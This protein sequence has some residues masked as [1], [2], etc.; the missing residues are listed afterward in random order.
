MGWLGGVALVMMSGC[1]GGKGNQVT[2]TQGQGGA[3]G[4]N[5]IEEARLLRMSDGEGYV[6]AEVVNPWDTTR[7]LGRYLLVERGEEPG[8]GQSAG[9]GAEQGAGRGMEQ[10]AGRSAERGAKRGAEADSLPEGY[11]RIEVPLERALVYSSVHGGVIA[12]MGAEGRIAGVADGEYF[13]KE[14]LAGRIKRGEVRNVGSSMAPSMEAIVALGPDAILLSPFENAGHGVVEH[15]GVPIIE[16]ADYM[17]NTPKGRAEWIKLLGVLFGE[18]ERADSIY[19]AVSAAY[20]SIAASVR[21]KG[22]GPTVLTEQLRDGYWFV[23]GG[24][25]YMARMIGDAGGV[26]PWANDGNTG[27]LQ[28]DFSS[29]YAKAGDADVWLIKSFGYETSLADLRNEYLLNSQFKAFKQGNVWVANTAEVPLYDEFP[30]HPELL[31]EEFARIFRGEKSGMRYYR[32][33]R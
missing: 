27:S 30:F 26:Y 29:V 6:K 7:L 19:G 21:G 3:E 5:L 4:G 12:E 9:R 32:K 18:R 22:E 2:G 17:E 13:T 11:A 23:P 33:A 24:E 25:S 10:G 31:L 28:L 8:A 16:C 1:G 15:A 20:D 14:P